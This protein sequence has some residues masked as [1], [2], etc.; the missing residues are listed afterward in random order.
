[1]NKLHFLFLGICFAFLSIAA[2]AQ[3]GRFSS[4]PLGV[5][6][7][8]EM[9]SVPEGARTL[10]INRLQQVATQT[11]QP[12]ALSPRFVLTATTTT[13]ER[14]IISGSNPQVVHNMELNLYVVDFFEK[15]IFTSTNLQLKGVGKT[16]NRAYL[17]AFRQLRSSDPRLTRFLSDSRQK[18]GSY[19]DRYCEQVIQRAE[20]L[21]I[22]NKYEEAYHTLAI[23]PES[24]RFCYDQANDLIAA[25]YQRYMDYVC[26][27]NLAK[28]QSLWVAGQNALNA[29]KA[30]EY[31]SKILPDA[32][33]YDQAQQLIADMQAKGI[34][35]N[36]EFE[37]AKY[38][39]DLRFKWQQHNDAVAIEQQRIEAARQ[40]GIEEARNQPDYYVSYS[41]GWSLFGWAWFVW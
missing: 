20:N 32:A 7:P 18:I 26:T 3:T 13:L 39:N 22:Q 28:A 37:M 35:E 17:A 41:Y 31:L 34:E 5:S 15:K 25:T 23:V 38:Y 12:S 24:N 29:T 9:D 40:V 14:E 4:I 30:G 10:L 11:G 8:T 19:Y 33:C 27:E 2:Q 1:M 6:L 21:I 16:D 36:W